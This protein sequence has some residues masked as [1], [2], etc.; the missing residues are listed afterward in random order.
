MIVIAVTGLLLVGLSAVKVFRAVEHDWSDYQNTVIKKQKHVA[1]FRSALGYGGVIHNFKNYVLRANT[2]YVDRFMKNKSMVLESVL[3]YR[4]I[5]DLGPAETEALRRIENLMNEYTLA[6]QKAQELFSEDRSASEVDAAIQINDKPYLDALNT[7]S[8]ELDRMIEVR[9]D[10]LTELMGSQAGIILFIMMLV[11]VVAVISGVWLLRSVLKPLNHAVTVAERIAEGN[12]DNT[13]FIERDDEFGRLSGALKRMNTNLA[14]IIEKVTD[15]AE[16]IV[17]GVDEIVAGN[18]NLSTRTEEQAS[19]LEET[20]ASMEEM[21]GTV[22]HNAENADH[23][24]ELAVS[25]T[26]QAETGGDIVLNAVDAMSDINTASSRIGDIITTIDG[27]AFQTNLLALNAAV[28]AA[29]AGEHGRGFAVVAAEVRALAQRSAESAKEIKQL[30]KDSVDKVR[31][32][33]NLVD[34][35]G[36]ALMGIV[37]SAKEV[38]E[39]VQE[40]AASSREQAG[41]VEQVNSAVINMDNMTQQNA[42]LVEQSAAAAR[43]MQKQA[44]E[45]IELMHY[46]TT[47]D[48]ERQSSDSKGNDGLPHRNY[49]AANAGPV[50]NGEAE[51]GWKTF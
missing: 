13:V 37:S 9:G 35:T 45:L 16:T 11:S 33:T 43:I 49:E 17:S 12:L 51:P 36:A 26:E 3:A 29:R 40:I 41:G 8:I 46:F 19:A 39:I 6:I 32:G 30:I 4:A 18:N 1:R 44:R 21:T 31:R 10:R 42:A 50:D 20:A 38:S 22:R 15:H 14:N 5:G 34:D 25:A 7:F 23:A 48:R 2:G 24:N 47:D 27:I 28:E